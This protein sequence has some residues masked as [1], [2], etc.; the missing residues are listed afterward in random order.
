MADEVR[1]KLIIKAA[2]HG[3]AELVAK[4]DADFGLYLVSEV[5]A[6]KGITLVGLLPAPFQSFV[7]YGAAAPGH[8]PVP[9]AALAFVQF[10]SGPLQQ[11]AWRASP[12]ELVGAR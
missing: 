8:S 9:R 2:I 11:E 7:V 12:L 5:Q 10:I 6:A 4:G 3:G 1:T